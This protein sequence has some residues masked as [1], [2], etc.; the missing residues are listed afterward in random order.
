MYKKCTI[1][2]INKMMDALEVSERTARRYLS[3]PAAMPAPERQLWQL[4]TSGRLL[5]EHWH[6]VR[7]INGNMV[8]QTEYCVS[9]GQALQY[10]WHLNLM[11]QL[12]RDQT[13]LAQRCHALE[14]R[15]LKLAQR[16]LERLESAETIRETL[17]AGAEQ[18]LPEPLRHRVQGC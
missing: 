5:P 6:G 3:N 2:D 4:H 1:L 16:D 12:L 18:L 15:G 9:Y 13:H 11:E 10:A 8:T 17:E 14:E 7:F